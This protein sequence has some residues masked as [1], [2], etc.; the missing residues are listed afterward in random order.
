VLTLYQ[1]SEFPIFNTSIPGGDVTVSGPHADVAAAHRLGGEDPIAEAK[2]LSNRRHLTPPEA[3]RRYEL[4][5]AAMAV[6]GRK[7]SW[8]ADQ[9]GF[10]DSNM[11]R[12]MRA[13]RR[14]FSSEAAA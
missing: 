10:S 14:A 5:L 12:L 1:S 8:V 6:G 9:L 4:I 11:S 2:A 13:A 3:R 7:Q